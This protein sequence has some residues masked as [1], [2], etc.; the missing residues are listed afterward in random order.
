MLNIES[1][2]LDESE[3]R[4]GVGKM[5]NMIS[6]RAKAILST[7][8]YKFDITLPTIIS[9]GGHELFQRVNSVCVVVLFETANHEEFALDVCFAQ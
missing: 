3:I 2:T 7:T 5:I 1:G 9:G 6:G 8:E 4:D